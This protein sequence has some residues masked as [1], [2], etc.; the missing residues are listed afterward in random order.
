MSMRWWTNCCK[1]AQFAAP[2]T[3]TVRHGNGEHKPKPLAP[4]SAGN[5]LTFFRKSSMEFEFTRLALVY[6]HL[7]A[8]CVA[9]GLVLM[10]DVAMVRQLMSDAPTQR[11]DPRHF[12]ELQDTVVLALAAL[13]ASGALIVALDT[14]FKGLEY[15][16]NPKL[17]AKITIVTLLTFNGVLLHHRVLP[18]MQK[19][20]NLLHLSFGQRMFAVFAGSVSGVSWAYAALMGVGR[21]LSWK[22][23]L[24][25]LLA[26]YPVLIAS[27]FVAMMTLTAWAQ[28]RASGQHRAF[29]GTRFAGA[30]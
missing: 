16:G 4:V 10:S 7:I 20:G 24:S 27:G 11:A 8:C 23:S 1:R 21:T 5:A 28:Y 6:A 2:D 15:F 13:W 17:Q 29:E 19:A 14:S 12:E 3:G 22:Y 30:Y 25:E 18:W 9:V 26:A